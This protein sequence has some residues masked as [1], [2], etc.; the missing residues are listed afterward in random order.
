MYGTASTL[1]T[2]IPTN[3][4]HKVSLHYTCIGRRVPK[5]Y[6]VADPTLEELSYAVGMC[7]IKNII[8]PHKAYSRDFLERGRLKVEIF[9]KEGKPLNSDIT[10][11][12][13]WT[14]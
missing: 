10:T 8:E 1:Y 2:S 13:K 7:R 4:L 9:D 12:N 6:A 11:S 5:E 14:M 3:Q